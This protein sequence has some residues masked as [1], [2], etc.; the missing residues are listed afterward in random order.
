MF[1]ALVFHF[2]TFRIR[3]SLVSLLLVAVVVLV[4]VVDVNDH[5]SF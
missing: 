4:V 3:C 2:F 1:V 5:P